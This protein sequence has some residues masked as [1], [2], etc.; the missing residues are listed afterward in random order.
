[1]RGHNQRAAE[2]WM[3]VS[4]AVDFECKT[5]VDLGCGYGDLLWRIKEAGAKRVLGVDRDPKAIAYAEALAA[6]HGQ[7]IETEIIDLETW[8]TESHYFDVALAFSSLVYVRCDDG[9]RGL[10]RRVKALSGEA[11]IEMQYF[12]DGPGRDAVF[13]GRPRP[14][15]HP[16]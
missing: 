1:V 2:L 5:V 7:Q 12:G 11:L 15:D 3:I 10:L 13:R 8:L 16:E 14:G 4:A 6:N 9:L